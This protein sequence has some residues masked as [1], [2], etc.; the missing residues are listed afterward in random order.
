M[1][2]LE[3]VGLSRLEYGTL[4][5]AAS[6]TSNPAYVTRIQWKHK[7]PDCHRE[8]HDRAYR[9]K[10]RAPNIRHD[11]RADMRLL[12]FALA[13]VFWTASVCLGQ[14]GAPPDAARMEQ[15]LSCVK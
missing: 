9:S 1:Q 12:T 15:R 14:E 13:G 4:G 3:A 6:A 2:H 10:P 7:T 11:R 5:L 8:E